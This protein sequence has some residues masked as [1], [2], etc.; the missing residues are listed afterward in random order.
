M[1]PTLR[2]TAGPGRPTALRA[3]GGGVALCVDQQRRRSK[4][5]QAEWEDKELSSGWLKKEEEEFGT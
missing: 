1:V 3:G 5:F 2:K 4:E